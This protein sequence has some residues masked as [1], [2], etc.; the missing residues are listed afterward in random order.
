MRKQ[1]TET[2]KICGFMKTT[3]LDYPGHIACTIFTG[4]CNWRCPFCHNSE[5]LDMSLESEFSEEEIFGFLDKRVHTLEGVVISG[6]EPTL[7]PDLRDF[8]ERIKERYPLKIKLDTNGCRPETV[9]ELIDGGLTDYIAMDIKSAPLSYAKVCGVRG[10][11]ME[12]IMKT[13][14]MLIGGELPYE[15]RTTAVKGLHT[16]EDF[17][18]IADFIEGCEDYYIQNFKSS[19]NVLDLKAG[20]SGF[21]KEELLRFG[22]I[23]A[24]KVKKVSLRGVD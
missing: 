4:G 24:P 14:D 12:S 22:D 6:G 9:K 21:S 16:E 11:D 5:L 2:M 1:E 15:L 8:M 7:Q 17:Y 13:K 18:G 10:V 3:L 20:F 19:D 23:V